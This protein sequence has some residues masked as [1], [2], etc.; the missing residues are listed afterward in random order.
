MRYRQPVD[1]MQLSGET[2]SARTQGV[3][4]KGIGTRGCPSHSVDFGF[5]PGEVVATKEV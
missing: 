4:R 5:A 3:R 2:S 1:V